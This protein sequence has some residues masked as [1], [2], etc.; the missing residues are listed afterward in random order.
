[1]TLAADLPRIRLAALVAQH[2]TDICQNAAECVTRLRAEFGLEYD[3]ECAALV[4]A[5]DAGIVAELQ[6]NLLSSVPRSVLLKRL[7]QR[8]AN[9]A[10]F[11][12]YLAEWSVECW[13]LALGVV[14]ASDDLLSLQLERLVPLFDA[15]AADET[16]D[17]NVLE[18]LV[19]DAVD[20]GID[21]DTARAYILRYAARQGRSIEQAPRASTRTTQAVPETG[22]VRSAETGI[23]VRPT[24][25]VTTAVTASV[26]AKASASHPPSPSTKTC[27]MP[28][29]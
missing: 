16:I 6:R 14:R 29:V 2:G 27:C 28:P 1:L 10:D 22:V 21:K 3:D 11:P 25:P 5:A 24:A 4:A 19:G 12:A 18:R 9:G 20:R 15:A 13:A 26:P 7:S 8:L 23:S 17:A